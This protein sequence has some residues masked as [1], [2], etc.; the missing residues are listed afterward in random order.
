MDTTHLQVYKVNSIFVK[1]LLTLSVI[2]I[3]FGLFGVLSFLFFKNLLIPSLNIWNY[4]TPLFQGLIFIGIGCN[5]LKSKKYFV[6][7]NDREISYLLPKNKE[8][9]L[10]KIQEIIAIGK[11]NH[12]I[13]I[14]L[15]NHDKKQFNLNHFYFPERKKIIDLFEEIKQNLKS[16]HSLTETD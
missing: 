9:E 16:K 5:T 8:L 15:N 6:S 7:W 11:R 2:L 4:V 3:L 10:I 1:V 13:M 14:E 12:L